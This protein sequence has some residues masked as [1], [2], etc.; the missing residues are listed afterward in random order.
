MQADARQQGPSNTLASTSAESAAAVSAPP[1]T[2]TVD[3]RTHPFPVRQA[4]GQAGDHTAASGPVPAVSLTLQQTAEVSTNALPGAMANLQ[5][6]I[7]PI[8]SQTTAAPVPLLFDCPLTKVCVS[9]GFD[10][11]MCSGQQ[12]TPQASQ[13]QQG[14]YLSSV[15]FNRLRPC[16]I[17][18]SATCAGLD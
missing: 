4:D 1:F 7:E 15:C 3:T 18:S 12:P 6:E 9:Q 17:L 8:S 16:F 10:L 11:V 13:S 5:L 2:S 14:C